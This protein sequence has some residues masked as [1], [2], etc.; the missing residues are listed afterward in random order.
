MIYDSNNP[1]NGTQKDNPDN[2]PENRPPE[3]TE[4]EK[5][6]SPQPRTVN[7]YDPDSL[8]RKREKKSGSLTGWKK[9]LVIFLIIAVVVVG[10]GVG[11]TRGISSLKEGLYGTAEEDYEYSSRYIGILQVHGTM[12]SDSGSSDTYN[13]NWLIERIDQMMRDPLNEGMILSVDTPGGEVYAID[14][15]YLKIMEY[16]DTGRPVYTYMESMAASGGYYISAGT[17]KIYANRNCWTGSIGV[18]IG[19]LYD[20]SGFL[21][22]MGIKTVTIDSGDNKSMGSSVQPLTQEQKEIF[23]SLVDEAYEQFIG[24]VAEGRGMSSEKA[25]KLGDG[26]V[27]TAKQAKENGLIDEIGTLEGAVNDMKKS[28]EL[29]D[30]DVHTMSYTPKND[31]FSFLS[32]LA[33]SGDSEAKT[34]YEQLMEL[35][36]E[37]GTFTITYLSQVRK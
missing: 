29:E 6:A 5:G 14:E 35:M 15:L 13:Q 1:E 24:V 17:D 19:T 18:T 37:N 22:K 12:S 20:I 27:Y 26:R 11:C 33:G 23:Q 9:G 7:T 2:R 16:M 28:Y 36:E 34:E 30:C 8:Y 4:E 25:K 10:A 21:E 32:G 3:R 31:L